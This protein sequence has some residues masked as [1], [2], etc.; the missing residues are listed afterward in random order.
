MTRAICPEDLKD[1][2]IEENI[3]IPETDD[4]SGYRNYSKNIALTV[5]FLLGVSD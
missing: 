4:K 2:M 5:G 1:I 3:D